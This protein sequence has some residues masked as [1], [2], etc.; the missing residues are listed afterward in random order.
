MWLLSTILE[1][2]LAQ[3]ALSLLNIPLSPDNS[4]MASNT[5]GWCSRPRI[6]LCFPHLLGVGVVPSALGRVAVQKSITLVNLGA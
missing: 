5:R 6:Y 2:G 1:R 3:I 4:R